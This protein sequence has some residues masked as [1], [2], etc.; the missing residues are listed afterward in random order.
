MHRFS[1]MHLS[2]EA[3][4]TSLAALDREEKSKVAEVVALIAVIDHRQDYLGAGHPSMCDYCVHRLHMSEDK[5]L[6]RIQVARAALKFPELFECLADGRLSVTTAN[7][8]A[9]HLTPENAAELLKSAAHGTKQEILR[10]VAKPATEPTSAPL[11]EQAE[12][13]QTPLNS[14]APAHVEA[15]KSLVQNESSATTAQPSS[16]ARRGR[17]VATDDGGHELRVRL[18]SEELEAFREAQSLLGHAIPSGDPAL[19]VARA[20]EVLRTQLKKR[21][22]GAKSV[23][24]AKT[25]EPAAVNG[26]GAAT[27]AHVDAPERSA[28]PST[29]Q[30]PAAKLPP[31][32]EDPRL[33]EY[34]SSSRSAQRQQERAIPMEMRSFVWRRDGG[35][36]A[37]VGK[38]GHRC[39]SSWKLEFDHITPLSLGGLTEPSNL[40][41]LCRAHNQFEAK[42]RLGSDHV[43]SKRELAKRT[44]ERDRAAK[45]AEKARA[46]KRDK[47]RKER[48]KQQPSEPK[49][50]AELQARYDDVKGA[51]VG[52]GCRSAE[53]EQFAAL[54]D[55]MPD[56]SLQDCVRAALRAYGRPLKLRSERLARCSA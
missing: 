17:I 20:M 34:L 39:N 47:D 1:R 22:F 3:A 31:A 4:L 25:A 26:S 21:R 9:P 49:R 29:V 32:D 6:K 28:P 30:E 45:K 35:C 52:L 37:F 46:A 11:L 27:E 40:R 53:A 42:R 44:R 10:L 48:E 2:P 56:A 12:N 8:V 16:P 23:E 33:T 36:C 15:C 19:V 54:V 24:A 51:M 41:L 5:A 13:V 38:D 55:E 50:S 7:V 18:T 14:H 43:K